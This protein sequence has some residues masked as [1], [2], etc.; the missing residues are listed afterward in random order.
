MTYQ[1]FHNQIPLDKKFYFLA[2]ASWKVEERV[3]WFEREMRRWGWSVSQWNRPK[4][5]K[6]LSTL[7]SKKKSYSEL[8]RTGS[9][10]WLLI[11]F[12]ET[13][14]A[15]LFC[16]RTFLASKWLAKLSSTKTSLTLARL[17]RINYRQMQLKYF[18]S[19][20]LCLLTSIVLTNQSTSAL[21]NCSGWSRSQRGQ[22][23]STSSRWRT[24][25]SLML[26]FQCFSLSLRKRSRASSSP[27]N[28]SSP[29]T[30]SMLRPPAKESKS[31]VTWHCSS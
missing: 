27:G 10:V 7:K 19:I 30:K 4:Q 21:V 3:R 14:K 1:P 18:S 16:P 2:K 5:Y 29:R 12:L 22:C 25:S 9:G 20:W 15:V 6:G 17:G 28:N 11:R 24:N 31:W 23:T 26:V 8:S 13:K